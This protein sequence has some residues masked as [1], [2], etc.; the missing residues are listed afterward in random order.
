MLKHFNGWQRLWVVLVALC[1][2]PVTIFTIE[3][4]PTASAYA[5]RRVLDTI[6]FAGRQMESSKP[7]YTFEGSYTVRQ[8]HYS[9]L[10]DEQII[11]R[12]HSKF[13]D[14]VDFSK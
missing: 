4:L 2:V 7:G 8:T 13:K 14:R 1:L 3:A 10:T 5:N 11:E 9:D 12:V 6:E